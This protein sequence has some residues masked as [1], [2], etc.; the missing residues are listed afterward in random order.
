MVAGALGRT[1][2]NELFG[3]KQRIEKGRR[4]GRQR[5]VFGL[6]DQSRAA[7]EFGPV[8]HGEL[9]DGAQIVAK[10]FDA[11]HPESTLDNGPPQ[12]AVV[13]DG[14]PHLVEQR[15][16][17][18]GR[19]CCSLGWYPELYAKGSEARGHAPQAR[20]GY[21]GREPMLARGRTRREIPA[22]A[23]AA[24]RDADRVD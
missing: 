15:L 24:E 16:V 18:C 20:I 4:A 3:A 6:R 9:L 19:V 22:K 12:L 5:V 21:A 10:V 8:V 23:P 1:E 11:I 2:S 14:L 7:D 17:D 13:G